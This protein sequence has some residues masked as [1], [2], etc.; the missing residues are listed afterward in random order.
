MVRADRR[1]LTRSEVLVLLR[2]CCGDLP[3]STRFAADRLGSTRR[4]TGS[5]PPNTRRSAWDQL[6]AEAADAQAQ[7]LKQ[8]PRRW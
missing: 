2:H 1:I 3:S 5:V 8:H 4:S 6:K 7:T